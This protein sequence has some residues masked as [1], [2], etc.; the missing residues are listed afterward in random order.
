M[1]NELLARHESDGE[2]STLGPLPA[3]VL[4]IEPLE[5]RRLLAGDV[6]LHWNELTRETMATQL[7]RF[8]AH[9]LAV[10]HVAMFDAVNSIDESHEPYAVDLDAPR[11]ASK[12]AAAAQAAHDT[13]VALYP[14]QRAVFDAALAEDLAGIPADRAAPGVAVGKE[15]ARRIL[16][17]RANDG[18]NDVE[19][20]TPPNNNP[21]Q[22]QPT[23]PNFLPAGAVHIPSVTPFA[24]KNNAQFRPGPPPALT[25]REYAAAYN[26][27]KAIGSLN[28]RVRTADQTQVAMLWFVPLTNTLA[29]NQ[30]AQNVA[31][32]RDTNLVENARAF[33]L[34]NIALNDA[35]ITSFASKFHYTLWRPVTAIRRG[36]E[37]GNP[38]TQGDPN[39]IM[40]HPNNPPYPAYAGNAATIG[41]TGATVLADVFGK[42][43]LRFE[44]DWGEF[45]FPGVTR[46]YKGFWAAA[47][48]Q[49]RSRVYGGVHY[50]F[51]STAGQLIGRN[52]GRYVLGRVLEPE[53]DHG[54]NHGRDNDDDR[55]HD[56]NG[57]R[58]GSSG[59]SAHWSLTRS[60]SRLLFYD[61][62]DN[63]L[64]D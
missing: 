40:L 50:T 41:A 36:A 19:T 58:A 53:D 21:G 32:D 56:Q 15:V 11:R 22:W 28:S 17:L 34:L 47:D 6:V 63:E 30:I 42:D 24:I 49:A 25:S 37:D 45:G 39:W 1:L 43:R 4:T 3:A 64:F 57:G 18:A 9:D 31:E 5:D 35:L 12:E 33:A 48:E 27:V 13:L 59:A 8:P 62:S 23:P 61:S 14:S 54:K 7:P 44:I 20:Y 16:Q 52:V 51:D 55:D 46:T 2:R 26:E 10:I 38:A 29:W 60:N